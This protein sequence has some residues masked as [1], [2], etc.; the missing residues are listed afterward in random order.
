MQRRR[1]FLRYPSDS[2]SI[3]DVTF[4]WERISSLQRYAFKYLTVTPVCCRPCQVSRSV[5]NSNDTSKILLATNLL[6]CR[7]G[8]LRKEKAEEVLRKM[9]FVSR[10]SV[11]HFVEKST[12]QIS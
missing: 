12:L 2:K 3:D 7:Y 10:S 8:D 5:H 11:L 1:L 9:L 4:I 6:Y